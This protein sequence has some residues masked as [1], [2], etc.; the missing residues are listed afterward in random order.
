MGQ[1]SDKLGGGAVTAKDAMKMSDEDFAKLDE[2]TL[3]RMR[4]DEL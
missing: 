4:G 1:D 3:A 2:K